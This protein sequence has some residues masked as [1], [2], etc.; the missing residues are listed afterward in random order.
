MKKA[1][2]RGL[3]VFLA[4]ILI[5][6]GVAMAGSQ[7]GAEIA[8][9]PLFGLGVALAFLIQWLAFIPAFLL[10]TEKFYDLT[11]SITYISVTVLA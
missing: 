9:L 3:L 11:G 8:E 6:L 10:Q 4:V 5:G 1:D 2:L 7:G